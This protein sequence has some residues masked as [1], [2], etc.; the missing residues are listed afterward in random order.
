VR[1][2]G[3]LVYSTCCLEPEENERVVDDFLFDQPAWRLV[4]ARTTLPA[5]GAT[6]AEWRDGGFAALLEQRG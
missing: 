1:P 2:G 5:W 4:E 6:A 3:R